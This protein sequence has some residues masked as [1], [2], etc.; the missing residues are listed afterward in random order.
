MERTPAYK[1]MQ[2]SRDALEYR[3]VE[4]KEA[5]KSYYNVEIL[6]FII[7]NPACV[8]PGQNAYAEE[9][10]KELAVQL[11]RIDSDPAELE[12]HESRRLQ[13]V[14]YI[15]GLRPACNACLRQGHCEQEKTLK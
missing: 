7:G 9:R 8:T 1:A 4:D 13:L 11:K 10:I 5:V 2:S 6:P 3:N 14:T 15:N 12:I